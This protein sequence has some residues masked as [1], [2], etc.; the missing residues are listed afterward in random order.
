LLL[1]SEEEMARTDLRPPA[2]RTLSQHW[3]RNSA[4][5][6]RVVAHS[7]LAPPDTVYE[8]GAGRGMLTAALAERVT[9]VV[10]VEQDRACW[11]ELRC[12]FAGD[13]RVSP[14]LGDFLKFRLPLRGRYA[15][16][17]NL[18]FG[19]TS[20]LLRKLVT[21]PNPPSVSALIVQREAAVH[22]AGIGEESVAS[23][24]AKVR[25][26]VE[27][28]LALRRRDFEPWP[29]VDC[30]LLGLRRRERP[31]VGPGEEASFRALVQ[32]GFGGG[33]RTL[34]ENLG[35]GS[36]PARFL[37][38]EGLGTRTRPG[39]LSFEQWLHLFRTLAP[40]GSLRIYSRRGRPGRRV[41]AI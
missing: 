30:V 23:V 8:A 24:T 36:A 18:P 20:A 19:S 31:A 2:A 10:A 16:A 41:G 34:W 4:V 22:W 32:R 6:Q 1:L 14:L 13:R 11:A 39:E 35:K 17:G 25:F 28:R 38:C 40:G 29:S 12:R 21:S 15:V 26:E 27:V 37:E 7:G 5:A 3:L 33:R 9:R